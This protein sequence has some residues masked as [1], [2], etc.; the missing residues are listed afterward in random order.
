MYFFFFFTDYD[1]IFN[2]LSTIQGP[3][4]IKCAFIKDIIHEAGRFKKKVLIKMLEQFEKS[5]LQ[6]DSKR[7][8]GSFNNFLSAR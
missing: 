2:Q 5:L 7:R 8:N 3:Q 1:N 4:E 6:S